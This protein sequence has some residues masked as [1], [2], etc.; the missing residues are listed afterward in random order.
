MFERILA[1]LATR[2][3]RWPSGSTSGSPARSTSAWAATSGTS[4]TSA[5]HLG[6][7]RLDKLNVQHLDRMFHAINE[8]NI[9][10]Q[11]QNAQRR[12][13]LDELKTVPWKGAENRARR[14]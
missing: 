11:E 2:R 13:A 8:A 6:E 10:I 14:K 3:R 7:I 12:A 1:V 9:E 4:A 5:S